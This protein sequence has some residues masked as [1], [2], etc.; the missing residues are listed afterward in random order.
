MAREDGLALLAGIAAGAGPGD[1]VLPAAADSA[2]VRNAL[3]RRHLTA[4]GTMTF[5]R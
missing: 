3:A 2:F 1:F 5:P 4:M